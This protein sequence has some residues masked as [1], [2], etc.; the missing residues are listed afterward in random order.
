MRSTGHM[1]FHDMFDYPHIY[2]FL[3]FFFIDNIYILM[4]AKFDLYTSKESLY[5]HCGVQFSN[6]LDVW[7]VFKSSEPLAW[8]FL[9]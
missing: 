8:P 6:N 5:C 2:T 3:F 4:F 1:P 9:L 7:F